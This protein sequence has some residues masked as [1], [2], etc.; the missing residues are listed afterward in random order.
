MVK[1]LLS[2][3]L[4]ANITITTFNSRPFGGF[5]KGNKMENLKTVIDGFEVELDT[6][7]EWS[8]CYV[9][10]GQFSGTLQGILTDGALVNYDTGASLKVSNAT[11]AKIEKWAESNGY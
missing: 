3:I 8:D 6:T 7:E 1:G 4:L 11:L 2:L 10:K 9:I 5:T